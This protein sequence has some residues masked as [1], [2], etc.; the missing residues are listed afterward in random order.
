MTIHELRSKRVTAEIS[1]TLLAA[2]AGVNRCR[3]SNIERGYV[4]PREDELQRL[5]TALEDLIK[6]K[7]VLDSVAA[8]VGWPL[9]ARRDQ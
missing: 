8:S 1:A 3:L 9:G 2:K 4:Q 7:S 6:A 5:R